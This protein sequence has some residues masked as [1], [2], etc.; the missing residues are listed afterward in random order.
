MR[1]TEREETI[2]KDNE[3]IRG[4]NRDKGYNRY[5]ARLYLGGHEEQRRDKTVDILIYI[6]NSGV[7]VATRAT[8]PP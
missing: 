8:G 5:L 2:G 3:T 4:H 7:C 6:Q 1:E